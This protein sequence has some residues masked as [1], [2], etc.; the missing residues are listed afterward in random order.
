MCLH[1]VK[2]FYNR[3]TKK[4]QINYM[5]NECSKTNVV[6]APCRKCEGCKHDREGEFVLRMKHEI[7]SYKGNT[8]FLTLTVNEENM[9]NVF[10]GRELSHRP[11]QLFMKRLRKILPSKVTYVVCGEY[12][13]K[14]NRPHYH[15][16]IFGWKPQSEE[17]RVVKRTPGYN[18][19]ACST[20]EK[21][22]KF[23]FNT[24]GVAN[25]SS[26][27]YLMKYVLKQ[28]GIEKELFSID[29]ET[30]EVINY[31]RPYIVYPRSKQN[32]G[33]GFRWFEKNK[34]KIFTEGYIAGSKAEIHLSIP[35]Y[36]KRKCE[37]L[38][39]ELYQEWKKNMIERVM[40]DTVEFAE[41]NGLLVR[42]EHVLIGKFPEAFSKLEN[43]MLSAN[44]I[45]KD[46]E[47]WK[48]KGGFT[49]RLELERIAYF[50]TQE[51]VTEVKISFEEIRIETRKAKE[52]IRNMRNNYGKEE[53]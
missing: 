49:Q 27:R 25:E 51:A 2:L 16:I 37:E 48:K 4:Y 50:L 9:E 42:P 15:A 35:K 14:K 7:E 22:W 33:L 17:L 46:K 24:V 41:K 47:S 13:A 40:E 26:S 10:P 6:Y 32:G 8:T 53:L 44:E 30:G 34:E 36:Y 1:P 18:L 3:R 52:N 12:G 20:I 11:F 31:K 19:Y 21:C 38:Y 43:A 45:L 28:L 39:P 29:D 23:G 5:P